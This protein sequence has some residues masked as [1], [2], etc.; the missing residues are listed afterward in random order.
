MAPTYEYALP[1]SDNSWTVLIVKGRRKDTTVRFRI[2]FI[3]ADVNG[4]MRVRGVEEFIKEAGGSGGSMQGEEA[5][6]CTRIW[7]SLTKEMNDE[8]VKVLPVEQGM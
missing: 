7:E 8:S 2:A 3:T 1:F 5:G 4:E 6:A